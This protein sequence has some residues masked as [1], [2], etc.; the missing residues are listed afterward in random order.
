MIKEE[1]CAISQEG[2]QEMKKGKIRMK[3]IT[4]DDLIKKIE[5]MLY[6]ANLTQLRRIYI[7]L[8]AYMHE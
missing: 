4:I 3:D 6:R 1:A 5:R 7:F 2:K 8:D